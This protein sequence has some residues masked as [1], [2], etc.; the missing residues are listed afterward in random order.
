MNIVKFNLLELQELFN[1]MPENPSYCELIELGKN[2]KLILGDVIPTKI[3]NDDDG[4]IRIGKLFIIFLIMGKYIRVSI[5][6]NEDCE[7]HCEYGNECIGNSVYLGELWVINQVEGLN[8]V[9][10]F[11]VKGLITEPI[12]LKSAYK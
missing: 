4:F 6:D 2:I 11:I 10:G 7:C 1:R 3:Y 8:E 9:L 12:R 5:C